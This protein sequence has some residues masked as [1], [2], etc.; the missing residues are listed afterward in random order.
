MGA[1]INPKEKEK[2]LP[3]IQSNFGKISQREIAR[4]LGIGKTSV[5]KWSAELG[6]KHKKH[7]VNEKFFNKW[8]ENC[9]YVLGY[10][11]SDGNI[12]WNPS[13]GYQSLTITASEKDKDHLENVRK[14]LSSTKP[15]LYGKSTNSF[16]MIVCN[17]KICI[18]LMK[19]GVVPRKSLIVKFPNIPQIYVRHFIR[20]VV[21]GDGMVRYVNRKRSP[22][23]EIRIA[24]G[25]PKFLR[26]LARVVN[27]DIS[28]ASKVRRIGGN[29]FEVNYTCRRG[30][31]LADWLYKDSNIFLKRKFDHYTI[32]LSKRRRSF[33][34][35]GNFLF[36]SESVTEGHPDKALW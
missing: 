13:K 26:K 34:R 10:I 5:N 22:Y 12:A 27:R 2:M 30:E 16:R 31:K 14:I 19:F 32:A 35:N 4:G 18:K 15:L 21:D 24:S 11:F 36:T 8:S 25:S 28:V 1:L 7:T 23:F 3:F 29:T 17:Q 9:A 33:M 20:G 6:L